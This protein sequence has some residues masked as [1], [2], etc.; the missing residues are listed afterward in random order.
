MP[1][2]LDALCADYLERLRAALGDVQRSDRE[3]II[4]QVSEHLSEAL[5]EALPMDTP[6]LL[7]VEIDRAFPT[8]L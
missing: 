8:L 3:Q 1:D 4:A 6:Y 7:E 5:R 2:D